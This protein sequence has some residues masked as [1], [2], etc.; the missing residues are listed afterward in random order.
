LSVFV[1][2]DNIQK[3][4]LFYQNIR[5]SDFTNV[6]KMINTNN[7]L[8]AEKDNKKVILKRFMIGN[9]I[10][11]QKSFETEANTLS[12]LRHPLIIKV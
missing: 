11:S 12:Q 4:P 10:A 7:I 2:Q 1:F 5:I 3:N 6:R 9:D 8:M